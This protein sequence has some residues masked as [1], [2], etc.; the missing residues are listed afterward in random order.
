MHEG[1]RLAPAALA[2]LFHP[3]Q[4]RRGRQ[5]DQNGASRDAADISSHLPEKG[6]ETQR[7][8][9]LPTVT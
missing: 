5:H 4:P 6:T 1:L 8:S 2:H 9:T 3:L 7:D